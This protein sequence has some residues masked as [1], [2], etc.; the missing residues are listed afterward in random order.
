MN[1]GRI[2]Y[3]TTLKIGRFSS[4]LPLINFAKL[5]SALPMNPKNIKK[6]SENIFRHRLRNGSRGDRTGRRPAGRSVADGFVWISNDS[7]IDGYL[8]D[9]VFHDRPLFLPGGDAYY[10]YKCVLALDIR[11]VH[12]LFLRG[13]DCH[14]T[15]LEIPVFIRDRGV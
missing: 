8:H 4:H 9:T 13:N 14:G 5:Q 12:D 10:G 7:F 6:A 3:L 2:I 15:Q 11:R 1:Q